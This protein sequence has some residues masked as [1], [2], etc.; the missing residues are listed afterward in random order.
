[1][2]CIVFF[3]LNTTQNRKSLKIINN[4]S[5]FWVFHTVCFTMPLRIQLNIFVLFFFSFL[6]KQKETTTI[7]IKTKA[8]ST[9]VSSVCI[10]CYMPFYTFLVNIFCIALAKPLNIFFSSVEKKKKLI[11]IFLHFVCVLWEI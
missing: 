2:H 7:E 8:H 1:M 10:S 4:I 5:F 11:F 6:F 9:P 3:I